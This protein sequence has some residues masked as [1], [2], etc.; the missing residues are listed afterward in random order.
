MTSDILQ[1]KIFWCLQK[2][3]GNALSYES[4]EDGVNITGLS[5]SKYVLMESID[6]TFTK[7]S[8]ISVGF[9]LR[10][11]SPRKVSKSLCI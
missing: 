6:L 11:Q 5:M 4:S 8:S 9:A 2:K 10:L 7:G 3:T 1:Y